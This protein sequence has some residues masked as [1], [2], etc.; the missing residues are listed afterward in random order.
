MQI[1]LG[2][3]GRIAKEEIVKL[4]KIKGQVVAPI[5]M[6][7]N[8]KLKLKF[9]TT[10]SRKCSLALDLKMA[11]N[12]LQPITLTCNLQWYHKKEQQIKDKYLN[13][14][15][16]MKMLNNHH[17]L[18]QILDLLTYHLLFNHLITHQSPG[19]KEEDRGDAQELY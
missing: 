7:L 2:K 18:K 11:A 12:L 15:N 17:S 6:N 4:I 10:A 8:Q 13:S 14:N 3:P 5:L 16:R 19:K 9:N 1:L